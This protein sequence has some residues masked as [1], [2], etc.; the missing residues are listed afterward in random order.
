MS[1]YT[2]A[3]MDEPT[4]S[5]PMLVLAIRTALMRIQYAIVQCWRFPFALSRF[6]FVRA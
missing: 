3:T 1:K 5:T 2:L 6:P 4:L